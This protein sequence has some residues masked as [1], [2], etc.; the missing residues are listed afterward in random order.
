MSHHS[1]IFASGI[2]CVSGTHFIHGRW[3]KHMT[4][5]ANPDQTIKQQFAA[6]TFFV[7]HLWF[8]NIAGVFEF[9][10]NCSGI[11]EKTLLLAIYEKI[12]IIFHKNYPSVHVRELWNINNSITKVSSLEIFHKIKIHSLKSLKEYSGVSF[13]KEVK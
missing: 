2:E 13:S 4:Y 5:Q 3:F 8:E 6:D 1:T 10:Y 11:K 12:P 7:F 9:S